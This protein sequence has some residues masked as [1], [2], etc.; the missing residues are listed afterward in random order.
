MGHSRVKS[1]PDLLKARLM[2]KEGM[3]ESNWPPVVFR[4]LILNRHEKSCKSDINVFKRSLP[5]NANEIPS[6]RFS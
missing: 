5:M 2:L 1:K 3:K 4:I 6:W